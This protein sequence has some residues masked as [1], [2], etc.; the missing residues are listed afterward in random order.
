MS[1]L[2]K[3]EFIE[4]IIENDSIIITA[5]KEGLIFLANELLNLSNDK[6]P[7]YHHTHIAEW[8]GLDKGS[9]ELILMKDA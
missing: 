7:S 2:K 1:E 6:L 5:T 9:V 3:V 4:T 8:N